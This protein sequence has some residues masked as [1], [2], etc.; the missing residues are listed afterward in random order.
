MRKDDKVQLLAGMAAVSAVIAMVLILSNLSVLVPILSDFNSQLPAS[1]TSTEDAIE[2]LTRVKV[3]T[4]NL[5]DALA[6]MAITGFTVL[7]ISSTVAV[8]KIH[9]Q[10]KM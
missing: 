10:Y 7:S 2:Q 8:S 5:I 3:P 6:L 4:L 1:A 9:A